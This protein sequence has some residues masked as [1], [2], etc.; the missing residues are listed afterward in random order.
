MAVL[1]TRHLAGGP[2]SLG[3]VE[4]WRNRAKSWRRIRF[5]YKRTTVVVN[6]DSPARQWHEL[7]L[8]REG[9]MTTTWADPDQTQLP[10]ERDQCP[11][12]EA[13][14]FIQGLWQLLEARAD[15]FPTCLTSTGATAG[16]KNINKGPG[17]LGDP[18]F[19]RQLTGATARTRPA[20]SRKPRRSLRR[21]DGTLITHHRSVSATLN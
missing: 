1:G 21:L 8:R 18:G 17:G 4:G 15:I 14:R 3:K 9:G 7:K 11:H 19:P 6:T 5:Y 12:A 16:H 10:K 2:G 13:G 20:V